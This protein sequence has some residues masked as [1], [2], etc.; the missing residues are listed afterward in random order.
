MT[1]NNYNLYLNGVVF[2][3]T[4]SKADFTGYN[5]I[6]F[7]KDPPTTHSL[8]NKNYVDTKIN[9]TF[10]GNNTFSGT[11][12]FT[13]QLILPSTMIPVYVNSDNE[14]YIDCLNLSNGIFSLTPTAATTIRKLK[15]ANPRAG[16]QYV[17]YITNNSTLYELSISGRTPTTTN[18]QKLSVI[19]VNNTTTNND[20]GRLNYPVSIV[21]KGGAENSSNAILS[22]TYDG[23][24]V[25]VACTSYGSGT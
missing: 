6:T 14:L 9:D 5:D 1:D 4:T 18:T 21:V 24:Y 23:T 3:S 13:K 16:G 17:I 7:S 8:T 20:V 10:S 15:I 19:V 25:Y 2:N 12:T 11:N 22:F